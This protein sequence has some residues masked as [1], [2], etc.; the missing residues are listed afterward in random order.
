M[1]SIMQAGSVA[2]EIKN[3]IHH[4]WTVTKLA[5]ELGKSSKQIYRWLEG[6]KCNSEMCWKI[7]SLVK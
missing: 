2:N 5:H 4:G 1:P 6:A 7:R 3:L